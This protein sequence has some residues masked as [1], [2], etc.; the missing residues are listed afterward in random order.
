VVVHLFNGSLAPVAGRIAPLAIGVVGGAQAGAR[1]S[2]K[3]HGKWILRALA[4]A[5]ASVGVRLL[6]SR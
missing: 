6:M 3:I 4:L 5:L 1:L 2:T